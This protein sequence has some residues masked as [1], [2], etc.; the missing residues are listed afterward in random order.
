MSNDH[1]TEAGDKAFTTLEKK[2][3]DELK[4]VGKMIPKMEDE[5]FDTTDNIILVVVPGEKMIY[6]CR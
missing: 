4:F 1:L 5:Q 3:R 6:M 2:D